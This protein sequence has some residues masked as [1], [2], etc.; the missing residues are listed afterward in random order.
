MPVDILHCVFPLIIILKI[1]FY[2]RKVIKK[3]VFMQFYIAC[4]NNRHSLHAL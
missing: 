2:T 3:C 1:Y 4:E